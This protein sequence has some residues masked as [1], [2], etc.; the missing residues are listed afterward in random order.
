[1]SDTESQV[2]YPMD[3]LDGTIREWFLVAQDEANRRGS[4]YLTTGLILMAA[5]TSKTVFAQRLLAALGLHASDQLVEAFDAECESSR[6]FF[7][8][9]PVTAVKESI[10][11]SAGEAESDQLVSPEAFVATMLDFPSGMATKI[12]KRLGV[13]P[14]DAVRQL[15]S[16]TAREGSP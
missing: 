11:K 15:R 10:L 4:G 7:H 6:P 1:M 16:G 8:D 14:S 13:D 5:G 2:R 9:E 12:L 3:R